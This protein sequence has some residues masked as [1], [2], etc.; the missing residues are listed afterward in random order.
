M[1]EIGM[2]C[3]AAKDALGAASSQLSS[4]QVSM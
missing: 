4:K 1:I 2:A 3:K